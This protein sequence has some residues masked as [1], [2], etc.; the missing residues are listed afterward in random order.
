ML[1]EDIHNFISFF[2]CFYLKQTKQPLLSLNRLD[3]NLCRLAFVI[4]KKKDNKIGAVFKEKRKT[5]YDKNDIY[6]IYN[7]TKK[8][9]HMT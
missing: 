9:G 6:T 1:N 7:D 5:E 2:V 8:T 3:T 4:Y